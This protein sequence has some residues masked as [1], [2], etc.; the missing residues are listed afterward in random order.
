MRP[1]VF[2]PLIDLGFLSLAA[3]VAILS[4]TRMVRSL[5]V[6]VTEI[7]PGI[8]ALLREDVTVITVSRDGIDVDGRRVER[9]A[10]GAAV[11]GRLALLRVG[12]DVPTQRLVGVMADL[13]AA[14]V[15][16][17]IEVEEAPR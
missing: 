4:Q 9:G 11:D 14:G 5:P 16:M 15:E 10:I 3:V 13:A 12:R 2:I 8:A 1:G 7:N 6:E 17:R